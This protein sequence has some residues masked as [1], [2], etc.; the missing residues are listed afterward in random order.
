MTHAEAGRRGQQAI[1]EKYGEGYRDEM[2][3]RCRE[4]RKAQLNKARLALVEELGREV[5]DEE[6]QKAYNKNN[7][8]AVEIVPEKITKG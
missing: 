1:R 4:S 6:A 2:A 5:T 8:L 3:R 7:V